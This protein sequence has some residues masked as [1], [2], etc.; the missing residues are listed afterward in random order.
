MTEILP[1]SFTANPKVDQN[2]VLPGEWL[3]LYCASCGKESGMRVRKTYL[4]KEFSHWQ[5]DDC[6]MKYPTPPGMY[7]TPDEEFW[8]KVRS[9]MIDEHGRILTPTEEARELANPSSI[10]SKL[11]KDGER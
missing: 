4:P 10:L 7:R 5:C 11:K 8:N 6:A 9:A 3:Y 1:N 2:I